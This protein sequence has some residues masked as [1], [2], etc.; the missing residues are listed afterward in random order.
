MFAKYGKSILAV[1]TAAI[2]VAYQALSGDANIEPTEWVSVAIAAVSA[3]G[4][5]LVPLAPGAKWSKTAVAMVLAVLQVLTTVI[6]GG[7]GADELL[8]MLITAAGAIGVYVAPAI[9]TTPAGIPD[10]IVTA[11][12][13]A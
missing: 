10:V 13:D 7:I 2:V 12:S 8:L 3:V 6:L 9:T 1:I 5:Y 11:G 4:V